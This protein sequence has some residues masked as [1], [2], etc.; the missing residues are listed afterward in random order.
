MAALYLVAS[1]VDELYD[2][3]SK[4]RLHDFRH[5]LWVSEVETHIGKGRVE[6]ATSRI[7]EL[8]ALTCRSWVFGI[9]ACQ[10]GERRLTL[11]DAVGK[12]SKSLLNP[13]YLLLI[14]LWCL[15]YYLHLHLRWDVRDAVV[16]E[17]AEIAAYLCRSDRD[18][19][20]ELF[21]HFLRHHTV[22]NHIVK[23]VSHLRDGLFLVFLKFLF[24]SNHLNPTVYLLVHHLCYLRL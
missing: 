1:L 5:L 19:L 16:G 6:H 7:V 2:M 9:E 15:G 12:L 22:A 11:G 4:F 23:F 3:V 8:A 14:N 17:I 13:V 10:G 21:L 18:V 20:D 24:R